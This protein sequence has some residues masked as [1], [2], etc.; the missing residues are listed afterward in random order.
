MSIFDFMPM[1][2]TLIE[3]KIRR[4][5]TWQSQQE[6]WM[7]IPPGTQGPDPTPPSP[8]Q[9]IVVSKCSITPLLLGSEGQV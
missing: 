4:T 7:Q 2:M 5:P 6:G 9:V 8:Q 3:G 1:G